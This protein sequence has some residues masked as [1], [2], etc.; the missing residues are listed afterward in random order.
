M[1]N[2]TTTNQ[3]SGGATAKPRETATAVNDLMKRHVL[4]AQVQVVVTNPRTGK[5]HL[6]WVWVLFDTGSD[7]SLGRGDLGT[8]GPFIP[9][10]DNV[11][12]GIG[13]GHTK[14]GPSTTWEIIISGKSFKINGFAEATDTA[15]NVI[16]LGF[17][18]LLGWS[19][20]APM[21]IDLNALSAAAM[22]GVTNPVVTL[23]ASH[24]QSAHHATSTLASSSDEPTAKRQRVGLTTQTSAT[25]VG[26]T[27]N[28]VD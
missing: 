4:R 17:D 15:N 22:R 18:L 3:L 1:R 20:I 13:G 27:P 2:L 6:V 21:G 24:E 7:T 9:A 23:I 19:V 26:P 12:K 11:I 25:S 8:T 14:F 10:G 16:P 5:R 28:N